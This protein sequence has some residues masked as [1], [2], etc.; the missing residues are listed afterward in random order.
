[1]NKR[2]SPSASF[3]PARAGDQRGHQMQPSA[4]A[5]LNEH[6]QALDAVIKFIHLQQKRSSTSTRRRRPQCGSFINHLQSGR[7]FLD[8]PNVLNEKGQV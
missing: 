1:M 6:A 7:T 2:S 5:F 8:C 3:Q 4:E